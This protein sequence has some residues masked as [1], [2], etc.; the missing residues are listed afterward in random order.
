MNNER[1]QNEANRAEIVLQLT[2]AINRLK[3]RIEI[4]FVEG[5]SQIINPYDNRMIATAPNGDLYVAVRGSEGA[6]TKLI[7]FQFAPLARVTT[8]ISFPPGPETDETLDAMKRDFDA[9]PEGQRLS[10]IRV[11]SRR[12]FSSLLHNILKAG[13][14]ETEATLNRIKTNDNEQRD[15]NAGAGI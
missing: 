2:D 14:V 6:S 10:N 3:K 4:L 7:S 1:T 5:N 15:T 11:I 12:E 9:R 8:I 13:L